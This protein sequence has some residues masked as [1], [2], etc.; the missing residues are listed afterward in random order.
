MPNPNPDEKKEAYISRCMGSKESNKSFPK[1]DQRAAFCYS[2]W[3]KH[4]P[5]STGVES[6]GEEILN[7]AVAARVI[8]NSA[9]AAHAKSAAESGHITNPPE[10]GWNVDW[11][12]LD[13]KYNEWCLG[14]RKDSPDPKKRGDWAFPVSDDGKTVNRHGVISAKQRA[15]QQGYKAVEA[16]ADAILKIIDSKSK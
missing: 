5:H 6:R 16:A 13:G 8:L 11:D 15:A 10:G 1:P 4:H 14:Q 3:K 7:F 12:K 2:N 9:G